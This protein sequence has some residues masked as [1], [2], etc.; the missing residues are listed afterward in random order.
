MAW[1]TSWRCF[2]RVQPGVAALALLVAA[3]AQAQQLEPRAYTN[4]PVG[5][6]FLVAGYAHSEGGLATDPSLPVDDA[7]LRIHT[8]VLA[9]ARSLDL[10]GQS[11][12]FDV[13]LP[14]SQLSGSALVAGQ[15][16]ER[17]VSGFG[18][19]AFRFSL[20]FYGA[21]AL[22]LS[23]FAAYRPDL[24]AG[25]SVQ[26]TA[27]AG[28]YDPG[29]AINLG[30]NRWSLKPDIGLSK[31]FGALTLDLTAA[32]TFYSRNDDY[33]GGQSLEQAPI[34]SMQSNLSYTFA[35]GVWAALGAT[36][37]SGGR[38][39]VNGVRKD[40]ALDNSRFGLTIAI[41]VDRRNSIKLNAS[42]GIST[43][44][45]TSFD[46]LGVAWQYRWGAGL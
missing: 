23:S 27:P 2:R 33:F 5:L 29:K 7:H 30:T 36:W 45:G 8:G 40:D 34:Y 24:V 12:K 4:L 41:P 31:S 39:T 3:A 32:V 10:W 21:P 37:Y 25:A 17:H 20:N 16:R 19:P 22:P 13:I 43:R 28:Q 35:G 18:D 44:T 42:S 9:Y 38:T 15:P 1:K 11:G 14:Y 46:T 26:L 6:N